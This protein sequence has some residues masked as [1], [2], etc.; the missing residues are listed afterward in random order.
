MI[1]AKLSEISE[2]VLWRFYNALRGIWLM[3][4]YYSLWDIRS[5]LFVF[6]IEN[7]LYLEREKIIVSKN[8]NDDRE[9]TELFDI[10]LRPEFARYNEIERKLLI[11]T[12]AYFLEKD[13]SFD[14]V[15]SIMTTYFD[16]D[17]EDQRQ[18]M[19][20]LLICL[21]RYGDEIKSRG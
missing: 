4:V 16:D 1:S 13:D 15:F 8:V 9:L 12:V 19:R 11:D 10:L 7:T 21:K 2:K 6:G 17:V 18:F 14:D 5:L 20:V 3:V